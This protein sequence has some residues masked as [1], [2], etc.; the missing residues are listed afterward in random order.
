MMGTHRWMIIQKIICPDGIAV[1]CLGPFHNTFI[2]YPGLLLANYGIMRNPAI[3]SDPVEVK[4]VINRETKQE[5]YPDEFVVYLEEDTTEEI[6][7]DALK[8]YGD[9]WQW[10]ISMIDQNDG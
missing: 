5:P 1:G 3:D 10:H 4:E 2:P 9:Q 8:L 7:T 6:V